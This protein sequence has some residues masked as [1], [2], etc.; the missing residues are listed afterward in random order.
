MKQVSFKCD[1]CARTWLQIL[2][3][4]LSID[5]SLSDDTLTILD[6]QAYIG[7]FTSNIKNDN[8]PS[9]ITSTRINGH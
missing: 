6:R 8:K 7:F 5:L 4:Q 2:D 1:V 3:E 9:S